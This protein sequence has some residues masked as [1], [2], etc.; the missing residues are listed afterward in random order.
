MPERLNTIL[1][2]CFELKSSDMITHS[3]VFLTDLYCHWPPKVKTPCFH[4]CDTSLC[5]STL[6]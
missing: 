4:E 5:L 3:S 2:A 1:F 6:H